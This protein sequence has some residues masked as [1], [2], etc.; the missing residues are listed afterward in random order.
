M[1][2][3]Q[4]Q[5]QP[6]PGYTSSPI[7]AHGQ[8]SAPRILHV[9]HEGFTHRRVQ[10]LDSDKQTPV[11]RI[12][13][14][15]GGLFSSKSHLRIHEAATN[16]EIATIT[17]HSMSSDIDMAIQNRPILLSKSGFLTSAHEFRSL[18]T[19]GSFKWKSDG[20]FSLGDMV[21]LDEREQLVARFESCAWAMKKAGKLELSGGINGVLMTEIVISGIAMIEYMRRKRKS[22]SAAA[23]SAG[24]SC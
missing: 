22:S 3:Y 4:A 15:S 5:H 1:A 18:A 17:F 9:Y 2:S 6:L 20:V 11:Y 7:P 23:G 21:C 14:N 16:A 10:I 19:G 12:D 13:A 24:G 8:Q